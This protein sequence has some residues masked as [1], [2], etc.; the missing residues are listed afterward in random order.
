MRKVI[1]ICGVPGTGKST[2]MRKLME[3]STWERQEQVKLVVSEYSQDLDLHILGKYDDGEVFAGT[4]KLSMAVSP[5]VEKFLGVT[6]SDVIFEGDRLTGQKLFTFISDKL[7]NQVEFHII[8]IKAKQDT[9]NSRYV[10]RGS[11]QPEQFL[12]A[13]ETKI[14]NILNN[15]EL[16]EF[17]TEF[18]NENLD[19]QLKILQF[20]ESVI[21]KE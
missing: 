3:S 15:F 18:D 1:A 17:I 14:N 20:I 13:K 2:L 21:K 7:T 16:S 4:D 10:E 11:T 19:D 5:E 12:N 6:Q 8:V 9:L